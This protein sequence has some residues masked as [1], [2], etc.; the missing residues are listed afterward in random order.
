MWG[1]VVGYGDDKV[2]F[3]VVQVARFFPPTHHARRAA[4]QRADVFTSDSPPP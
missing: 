3:G 2:L 4:D 1:G